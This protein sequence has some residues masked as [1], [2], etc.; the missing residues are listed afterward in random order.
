MARPLKAGPTDIVNVAPT[1]N[2]TN[3]CFSIPVIITNRSDERPYQY[4][5]QKSNPVISN[6]IYIKKESPS[7]HPIVR[8]LPNVLVVNSRSI[9]GKIDE[10]KYYSN[11][12]K[13]EI[14]IV[15][16]TWLS[17]N[18]PS[19]V[20]NISGF[21]LICKDRKIG[22][23]GG[24]AIYVRK[25]FSIRTRD[26]LSDP[27][28]ECQWLTLRPKWLPRTISRI[29]V[30]CVYLT[31]SIDRVSLEK[32]YDYFYSCYDKVSSESPETG[33]IVAGDF[34]PCSNGFDRKCLSDYCDYNLKQVVK[35]PTR[36]SNILDHIFTNMGSHYNPPE[37]IAPLSTSDHNMVI[38]MAKSQQRFVNIVKKIK[39][40]PTPRYNLQQ[41][42]SCLA[43]YEWSTVLNVE[44][45][46]EKVE[47]FTRAT[48]DMINYYFPERTVRM[49][50]D[51]NFFIT[52]KIK[53]LLRKRDNAYK[54]GRMQKFR[55]LR[56]RVAS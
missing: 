33:F 27:S 39:F 26:D 23:G 17:D 48:N 47:D 21:I 30:D 50:S 24:C 54:Q 12:H 32:F 16:E 9:M 7:Y 18:I 35:D 10:L 31:P 46:D 40:R 53:R 42:G 8:T 28:F 56:N 51:D 3:N 20:V 41:F 45:V 55:E 22:P 29:A 6:L 1:T 34:N 19:E 52:T 2:A 11:E 15:T 36:N 49:H 13:I 14:I 43:Q 4:Y 5:K 37:V 38:W 25:E 44:N